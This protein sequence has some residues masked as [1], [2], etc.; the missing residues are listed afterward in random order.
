MRQ[1]YLCLYFF[2]AFLEIS[3]VYFKVTSGMKSSEKE[4]I[5]PAEVIVETIVGLFN[6]RRHHSNIIYNL[7]IISILAGLTALPFISIDINIKSQALIRPASEISLIKSLVNGRVKK[8]FIVE[9]QYINKGDTLYIVESDIIE[10][11]EKYIHSKIR[12]TTDFIGDLHILILYESSSLDT[13]SLNTPNTPFYQQSLSNYKQ[14]LSES[15]TH[16]AKLKRD[17]ERNKKL[18]DENVIADAEFENYVFEF[19]KAE[20]EL[21]IVRQTQLSQWQIEL[22]SYTKELQEYKN[23]YNQL[24]KEK[25]NLIIKAPVSGTIQ[26]V[27]GI[28][29]GSIIFSNQ[30]LNQISPDTSFVAEVYVSPSDIGLLREQMSVKFQVDAFNYNQW[31]LACGKVIALPNDVQIVNDK[32]VFKVKCSLDKDYMLL[33][34]GYKGYLK[35]GMTLQARFIVI[36]RTLWQLLYDDI[37]DWMNPNISSHGV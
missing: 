1:I 9:N 18:H 29:P 31:G 27:S 20:H 24:L 34:N 11:K 26:N 25:G 33:K 28:Y 2:I 4:L 37:D 22:T 21:E 12:E 3:V 23:Q 13:A 19:R 17:Y 32:P 15:H 16:L 14:K 36:K 6:A 35:K 30:D 10:E 5:L 7:I 8:I